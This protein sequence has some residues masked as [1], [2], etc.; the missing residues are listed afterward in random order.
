MRN[1]LSAL[2]MAAKIAIG[3]KGLPESD[4]KYILKLVAARGGQVAYEFLLRRYDAGIKVIENNDIAN[5]TFVG[6]GYGE[7]TLDTYRKI[8]LKN[9]TVLFEKIYFKDSMDYKK[10]CFFYENVLDY[11]V[12]KGVSTPALHSLTQGNLLAVA[13]LP[14]VE[15][16]D[17]DADNYEI[18]AI[19][20][21]EKI[22]NIHVNPVEGADDFLFD[23]DYAVMFK[24]GIQAVNNLTESNIEIRTKFQSVYAYVLKQDR[25]LQHGDLNPR[26]IYTNYLIDW[27]EFGMYPEGYDIGYI[28][29]YGQKLRGTFFNQEHIDTIMVKF[30][31]TNVVNLLFFVIVFSCKY[32]LFESKEVLF[33]CIDRLF[34]LY[35]NQ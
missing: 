35:N 26:N 12:K 1:K 6:D 25:F 4:V 2:L 19:K 21:A 33:K 23:L 3:Y 15:L 20:L 9:S 8:E 17:V 28:L 18:T 31:H 24:N 16:S 11:L 30:S 10:M 27:D 29:S 5:K 32:N 7:G 34:C 22:K 13:Y 14:F